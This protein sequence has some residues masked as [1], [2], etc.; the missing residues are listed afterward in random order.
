[1]LRPVFTWKRPVRIYPYRPLSVVVR[2]I[3]IIKRD[4][5]LRKPLYMEPLI[6]FEPT[7][8]SLRMRCSTGWAKVASTTCIIRGKQVDCQV[9]LL[10]VRL[11]FV[12]SH[13]S[14]LSNGQ[15][16][17][18][19]HKSNIFFWNLQIFTKFLRIGV[20]GFRYKDL[21]GY[22]HKRACRNAAQ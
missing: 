19:L 22:G 12:F 14:H 15:H 9:P 17:V 21:C 8:L 18:Q 7:T 10:W 2:L 11:Y 5:R 4:F 16:V 20:L 13:R 3:K 1:M 6:G